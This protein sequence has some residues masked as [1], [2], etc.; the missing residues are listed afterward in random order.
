MF[1]EARRASFEDENE[2]NLNE[3]KFLLRKSQWFTESERIDVLAMPFPVDLNLNDTDSENRSQ[4]SNTRET[5]RSNR[6]FSRTIQ[7]RARDMI[8]E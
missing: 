5:N 2:A 1:T 7:Q 8:R 6:R 4:T 3:S